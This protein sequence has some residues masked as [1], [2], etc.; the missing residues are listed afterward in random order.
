MT[1]VVTDGYTLNS[2]DLSWDAVNKLGELTVYDRTRPDEIVERCIHADII[3]TNKTPFTH[4][5]L[6][7]LPKLKMISVLATGY[8]VIDTIAAKENNIVVCNVPGYGTASVAQHVFALLLELTNAVGKHA[9]STKNGGWQQAPDWCYTLQ[10]IAEL[11]GK[12]IGIIGFGSIGQQV[13]RIAAAFDMQVIFYNPRKKSSEIG[14]QVSL[15]DV[16]TTSDVVTLHC[17]LTEESK[18]LVNAGSLRKMKPS[19]F[20]INT[21]RG[22]LIAEDDL[23]QALNNGVI[24]GAALDV[25]CQEPPGEQQEEVLAAR[26][27]LATP[28]NAWMSLE[29][30]SRMMKTTVLNIEGFLQGNPVNRIV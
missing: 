14:R 25:L 13:A 9:D 18:D 20:L 1:I 26:N 21:A 30:R 10:P 16:F 29:A 15:D 11:S 7:A 27:C 2:G 6:A 22:P 4:Q 5:T 8:N 23:V 24:A 17:P 3:L 28:H 12:T 19:A